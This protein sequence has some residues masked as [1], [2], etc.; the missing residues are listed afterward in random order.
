MDEQTSAQAAQTTL[1]SLFESGRELNFK[2]GDIVFHPDEAKNCFY[3]IKSGLIKCFV[4]GKNGDEHIHSLFTAGDIFPMVIVLGKMPLNVYF[5]A[6][7]NTNIRAL[8]KEAFTQAL[9]ADAIL[10]FEVLQNLAKMFATYML[11]VDN[12]EFKFARERLAYRLLTLGA[13]LGI[14]KR[15]GFLLPHINQYDIGAMIN[16]SRE[17]VSRE[18]GRFERLGYIGHNG[19]NII[20]KDVSALHREIGMVDITPGGTYNAFFVLPSEDP[21]F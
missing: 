13:K 4:I 6:V 14:P 9:K 19:S 5:Q 17:S 12:L 8:T 11:R 18:L 15:E 16:L 21:N 3:F 1:D 10:C 20:I 7:S 2:K